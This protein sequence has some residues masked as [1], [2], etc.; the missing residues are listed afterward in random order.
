MKINSPLG[1]KFIIFVLSLSLSYSQN[2]SSDVNVKGIPKIE[3]C[4]ESPAVARDCFPFDTDSSS[5]CYYTFVDKKGCVAL[6]K[7]HKGK[8][9]YGSLY[10]ECGENFIK[11]FKWIYLYIYAIFITLIII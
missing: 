4:G 5:C 2:N 9:Y 6:G 10:I 7:R 8:T 1:V 3:V 11:V